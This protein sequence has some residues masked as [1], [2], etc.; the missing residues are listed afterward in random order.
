MEVM[1][2][3][4]NERTITDKE[5]SQGHLQG[6]FL[7]R[8]EALVCRAR[9]HNLDREQRALLKRATYSA[10]LDCVAAGVEEE[11]RSILRTPGSREERALVVRT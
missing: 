4:T 5:E 11:A 6:F 9:D 1:N 2:G 7:S 8:M 10:Y 3:E